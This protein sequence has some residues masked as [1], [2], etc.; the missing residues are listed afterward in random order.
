MS[1]IE[2][3][4]EEARERLVL[5]AKERKERIEANHEKASGIIQSGDESFNKG[6]FTE[7]LEF[8]S[9]AVQLWNTNVHLLVKLATAHAKCKQFKEAVTAATRA[10]YM[11]PSNPDARFQRGLARLELHKAGLA[12]IDLETVLEINP[13]YPG[14]TSALERVKKQLN[15]RKMK[16]KTRAKEIDEEL[17]G[18]LLE[19]DGIEEADLS[20]SEE[21]KMV[22]NGIPCRHYNKKPAGC[23]E[24]LNCKWMH[25]PDETS[26][27]DTTGRNVCIYH[28]LD[29]CQFGEKCFYS[30]DKEWL[31]PNGWWTDPYKIA[32]MEEIVDMARMKARIQ[33]HNFQR[34]KRENRYSQRS[35]G[36]KNLHTAASSSSGV[37]AWM[38]MSMDAYDNDLNDFRMQHCGFSQ[39]DVEELMC[40][41]VK[42]WDDDA[43][44][45]LHALSSY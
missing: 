2:L 18:P 30:H 43:W 42:P 27:R 20:D 39:G 31:P 7:A 24:G 38:M 16:K 19:E 1:T 44:D 34:S 35:R 17:M 25:A 36:R 5:K 45:V 13:T 29:S 4:P 10:L 3:T 12:L 26:V 23:R 28:L 9:Q 33:Q 6:N 32:V 14:L 22:G 41:G 40:Q 15:S 8:Y 21:S 37:P 11:D